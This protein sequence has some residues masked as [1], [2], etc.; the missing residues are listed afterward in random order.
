MNFKRPSPLVSISSREDCQRNAVWQRWWNSSESYHTEGQEPQ[1]LVSNKTSPE[2]RTIRRLI[3]G[4]VFADAN[5]SELH[6][7]Y[8]VL[9]AMLQSPRKTPFSSTVKVPRRYPRMSEYDKLK[10]KERLANLSGGVAVMKVGGSSE[11][12][13]S[14]SVSSTKNSA[15]SRARS[16]PAPKVFH[17]RQRIHHNCLHRLHSPYSLPKNF[18]MRD[19]A[20]L[21]MIKSGIVDPLNVLRTALVDASGVASL[22][23]TSDACIFKSEE[24]ERPSIGGMGDVMGG[25]GGF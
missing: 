23:V 22:L 4:T 21:E 9:L 12:E 3:G 8:L 24:K 14:R 25:M 17:L 20:Q 2:R 5:S 6:P 10:L 19:D 7:A 16:Q 15:S 13:P 1:V 11:I 18:A